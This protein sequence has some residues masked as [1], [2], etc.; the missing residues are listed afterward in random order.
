MLSAHDGALR[1]AR[2]K[3]S[4]LK[5]IQR[6]HW[7]PKCLHDTG[8]LPGALCWRCQYSDCDIVHLLWECPKI[9]SY[10]TAVW[11]TMQKVLG[12]CK[13]LTNK[14]AILHSNKGY[15]EHHEY[16]W[17]DTAMATANMG[18]LRFWRT[19]TKPKYR[20]WFED[21]HTVAAHERVTYKVNDQMEIFANHSGV[22]LHLPD[23][24]TTAD[25]QTTD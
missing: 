13:S 11:K 18:I 20:T 2:L 22:F 10:W 5:A 12:T 7:T 6:W 1:N 23:I 25:P 8:L 14:A 16:R 3:L 24:Y 17:F 4:Y 19:D 21:M 15:P 9:T